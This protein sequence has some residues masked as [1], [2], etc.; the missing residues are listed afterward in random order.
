M[1]ENQPSNQNYQNRG[2]NDSQNRPQPDPNVGPG[3]MQ[4]PKKHSFLSV[5]YTH[6]DVYKRQD[7][8]REHWRQAAA[9][10]WAFL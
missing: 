3:N 6:L 2:P 5:S 4:G 9:P 10:C 1:N 8:I 7:L